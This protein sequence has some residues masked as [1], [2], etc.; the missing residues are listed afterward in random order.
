MESFPRDVQGLLTHQDGMV[1]TLSGK[2]IPTKVPGQLASDSECQVNPFFLHGTH[3]E[4]S[5]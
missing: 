2:D 5:L 4:L 3:V 1:G